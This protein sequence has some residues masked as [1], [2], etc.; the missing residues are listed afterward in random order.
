ML[1][2]KY[3]TNWPNMVIVSEVSDKTRSTK[4]LFTRLDHFSMCVPEGIQWIA[5]DQNR[6]NFI[7]QSLKFFN[8]NVQILLLADPHFHP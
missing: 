4:Y 6:Y 3:A 7:Q 5:F 8:K 1:E 2:V